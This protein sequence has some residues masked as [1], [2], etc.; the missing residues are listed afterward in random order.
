MDLFP[1]P[2]IRYVFG[3]ILI[4][5]N[6]F[7]LL[8]MS[9]YII[10]MNN[11]IVTYIAIERPVR[12]IRALEQHQRSFSKLNLEYSVSLAKCLNIRAEDLLRFYQ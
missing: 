6:R 7:F 12:T 5:L 8:M 9:P 2:D 10:R 11:C 1:L 3:L 4:S